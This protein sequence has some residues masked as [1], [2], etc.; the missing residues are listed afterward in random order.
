MEYKELESNLRGAI[1]KGLNYILIASLSAITMFIVPLLGTPQKFG[2]ENT[3][4]SAD[5]GWNTWSIYIMMLLTPGLINIAI[6]E[7]F[8]AEGFK[9]AKETDKYR[10]AIILLKKDK[11]RQK[12]AP[13]S[14][15]RWETKHQTTR[16]AWTL[17]MSV[18][19][20]FMI[21]ECVLNWNLQTF[22]SIVVTIAIGIISGVIAMEQK[23]DYY[24]DGI[25]EY[26]LYI[27]S[28]EENEDGVDR[29]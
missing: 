15:I 5:A 25:L 28:K 18:I 13:I 9:R 29:N 1:H 6:F 26:A 3:I 22:I 27:T 17:V 20:M 23:Y 19:S 21:T 2:V 12:S 11:T 8:N 10:R 4:P 7:L 14:P 24:S 16:I